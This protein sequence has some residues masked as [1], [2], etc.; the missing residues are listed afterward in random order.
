MEERTAR[1]EKQRQLEARV[2]SYLSENPD[3]IFREYLQT[4]KSRIWEQNIQTELLQD[5]LD[6]SRQMY[7]RRVELNAQRRQGLTSKEEHGYNA[8]AMGNVEEGGNV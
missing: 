2:N 1:E 6:R 5:E 8:Q 4:L 7:L 3:I